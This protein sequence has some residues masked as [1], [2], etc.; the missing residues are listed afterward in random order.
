M[1]LKQTLCEL[2]FV[3]EIFVL[4]LPVMRWPLNTNRHNPFESANIQLMSKDVNYRECLMLLSQPKDMNKLPSEGMNRTEGS[5]VHS[6][7]HI[8]A[9]RL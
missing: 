6:L 7:C 8:F 2:P 5:E 4:L 3:N 9:G 1:A